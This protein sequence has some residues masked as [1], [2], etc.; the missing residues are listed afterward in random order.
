MRMAVRVL[1]DA[2]GGIGTPRWRVVSCLVAAV[3][4]EVISH[5]LGYRGPVLTRTE[6]TSA[7]AR[8]SATS[9]RRP[10]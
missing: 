10:R 1:G 7:G 2:P 4:G 5:R 6:L 3:L 9:S 8:R